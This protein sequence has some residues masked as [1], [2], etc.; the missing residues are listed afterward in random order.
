MSRLILLSLAQFMVVLDVTVVNVALPSIGADLAFAPDD[1]QWVVTA[2]VLMTGGLLLLGGRM[3]DLL[4]RRRMFLTGLAVFTAASLASGLASSPGLLVAARTAQGIGAALLSP[5]AL[6]IITTTFH[7]AARTRALSIW[8]AIGAGGAA[9]GVLLGGVLTSWLGWEAIFFINVPVGIVAAA[10][11][12]RLVRRDGPVQGALGRLDLPG[13]LAAV[14]GLIALVYGIERT[15]VLPVLLAAGLLSLFAVIER[16]S[17][18]PLVPPATWR[19]RSLVASGS[20]MLGGTGLLVGAFFLNS[21]FLQ[22]TLGWSALETGVAFLPLVIVVGLAAHI[23]PH[24]LAHAGARLVV[25]IGLVLVGAGN[26]LLAAAPSDASYVADLLPGFVALG[27]G[28]GLVFVSVSVTAM[29]DIDAPRAGLASGLMT[30]AH[31][32]GAA[33]GVALFSAIAV[34]GDGYA[35]GSYAAA[36]LAGTL[37]LAA[38]VTVPA[39]RP[40]SAQHATLH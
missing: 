14:A 9:A 18:H 10:W 37:A 19:V 20:M 6:S 25:V 5:A 12:P 11:T 2:Y 32:I 35:D 26:L 16:G 3:A 23:G 17:R 21:L 1:L 39:F 24:L 36:A 34:G 4:G 8:G 28:I 15:D 13:A 38:L 22:Q 27:F 31:E 33:L 30:T 40:S 29:A 7:G